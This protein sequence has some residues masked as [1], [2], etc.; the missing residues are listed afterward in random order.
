MKNTD[1]TYKKF[2]NPFWIHALGESIELLLIAILCLIAGAIYM[3]KDEINKD[4]LM[5][6][7][8]S[9]GFWFLL[10][11]K[12]FWIP[13][14]SIYERKKQHFEQAWVTIKFLVEEKAFEDVRIKENKIAKFFPKDLAVRRNYFLCAYDDN[15]GLKLRSISSSRK[16]NKILEYF[17][18]TEE[19]VRITYGKY[20]KVVL[21][22]ECSE[23]SPNRYNTEFLNRLF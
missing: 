14:F 10:S 16:M 1:E 9:L 3:G 6:V 7:W 18:D 13:F 19:R 11:L 4:F 20:T 21:K 22:I 15:R 17:V 23:D 5:I 2:Y 8:F 12:L